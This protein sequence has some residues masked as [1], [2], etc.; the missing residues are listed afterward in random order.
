M[1]LWEGSEKH[2][3]LQQKKSPLLWCLIITPKFEK[4]KVTKNIKP[5][6][7]MLDNKARGLYLGRGYKADMYVW[8]CL[9]SDG[10]ESVGHPGEEAVGRGT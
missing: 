3:R 6:R 4:Y 1:G 10:G 9:H 2:L 8:Q 5:L 7:L